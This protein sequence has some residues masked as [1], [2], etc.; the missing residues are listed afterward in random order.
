MAD[1]ER[2]M[3]DTLRSQQKRWL[4]QICFITE[5]QRITL[6]GRIQGKKVVEDQE[7]RSWIGYW[8]RK[9]I[10][11]VMMNERWWYKIDLDGVSEDW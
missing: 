1:T 9:K 4:G 10:I 6:E 2:E 5:N 8:R 7:Q 11:S 3:M